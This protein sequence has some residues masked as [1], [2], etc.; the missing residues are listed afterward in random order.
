MKI[1]S[2]GATLT[3]NMYDNNIFSTIL[4]LINDR[5]NLRGRKSHRRIVETA[6]M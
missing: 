5:H 1:T 4:Y 3:T 6:M 2:S